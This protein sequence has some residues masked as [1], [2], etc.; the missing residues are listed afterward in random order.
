MSRDVLSG[1][2]G[3]PERLDI[4]P[5]KMSPPDKT[6]GPVKFVKIQ[7]IIIYTEVLRGSG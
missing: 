5:D 1:Q 6:S 3:R 7:L 4:R 2:N